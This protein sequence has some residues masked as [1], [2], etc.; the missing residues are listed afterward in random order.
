M[1]ENSETTLRGTHGGFL[2]RPELIS[3]YQCG[4]TDAAQVVDA[5]SV[6][7]I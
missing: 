4:S 7:E 3:K 2:H 6:L 5:V 1:D